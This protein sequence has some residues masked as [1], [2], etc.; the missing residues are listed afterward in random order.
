[1]CTTGAHQQGAPYSRADSPCTMGSL[2]QV[3]CG[4]MSAMDGADVHRVHRFA[5]HA[6]TQPLTHALTPLSDYA[7]DDI[8][9]RWN[10]IA[11]KIAPLGYK[12]YW[13]GKGH[14]GYKSMAHLPINRGFLNHTGFLI[15]SQS[16]TSTGT[17][18]SAAAA[19]RSLSCIHH[20]LAISLHA[21]ERWQYDAPLNTSEYGTTMCGDAAVA[22][23]AAHDASEPF[24]LYLPWQ[25]VHDPYDDV[26]GWNDDRGCCDGYGNGDGCCE[27]Y[28]LPFIT[29][30][31]HHFSRLTAS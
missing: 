2:F 24:F 3:Q 15:G 19:A 16:Y 9:L 14:T 12:S 28:V 13:H 11:E 1:M 10:T 20:H 4:C 21:T 31:S 29:R 22:S 18:H 23:L 30:R 27:R 5:P 25:A 17:L 26:P 6:S 8:D 7:S